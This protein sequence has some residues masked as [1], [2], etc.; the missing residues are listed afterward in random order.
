MS[1]IYDYFQ[2]NIKVNLQKKTPNITKLNFGFHKA[3][4]SQ[5]VRNKDNRQQMTNTIQNEEFYLSNKRFNLT[6]ER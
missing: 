1:V 6:G 2:E 5:H 3:H 4:V